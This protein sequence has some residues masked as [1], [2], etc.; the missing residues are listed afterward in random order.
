MAGLVFLGIYL[1]SETKMNK[2]VNKRLVIDNG[3]DYMK[4]GFA[5]ANSPQDI[6][7]TI[8][9]IHFGCGF[10]H[11]RYYQGLL[12]GEQPIPVCHPVKRGVITDWFDM[13][14]IWR[15]S[16]NNKLL[17]APEECMVL[18]TEVPFNPKANKERTT[19]IMFE[20]FKI[21]F[22]HQCITPLLSLYAS[23]RHTGL[24][25]DSGG[26][27]THV[28]PIFK[29]HACTHA[30]QCHD[31]SGRTITEY[32]T[33]LLCDRGYSFTTT[34]LEKVRDIKERLCYVKSNASYVPDK[35]YYKLPDGRRISVRN[36]RFRCTE[37]IF[38]PSL[39]GMSCHG[40]QDLVYYAVMKC[41]IDLRNYLLRNILLSGGNTMF[42][43]MRER[44]TKEVTSLVNTTD[45]KVTA[46]PDRK[47][48]CWIGGSILASLSD[49]YKI[50]I[51]KEEYDEY[52]DSIVHR[53]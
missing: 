5:G 3:T 33:K 2:D 25:I 9:H 46:P 10:A 29:Y 34:E 1:I 15:Q 21:P 6:F 39:F 51:S 43:G 14:R 52:G 37:E 32:L 12:K 31:I 28:V 35:K 53:K 42:P 38:N 4:V 8:N 22:L 45:V 40:L 17:V 7:P 24:V 48:S 36:E 50:C 27:V 18:M 13:E 16:F 19:Q 11:N 41:D 23:G 47:L 49:F 30:I 20:R 26:G 44:V